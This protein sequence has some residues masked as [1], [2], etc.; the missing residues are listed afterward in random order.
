MRRTLATMDH[1]RRRSCSRPSRIPEVG[2]ALGLLVCV[3]DILFTIGRMDEPIIAIGASLMAV[4]AGMLMTIPA[5]LWWIE[6]E[7]VVVEER[8]S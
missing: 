1:D 8:G 5:V 6:I 2:F 3:L 7:I 4:G